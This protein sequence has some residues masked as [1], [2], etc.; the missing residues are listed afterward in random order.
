MLQQF[1][2]IEFRGV[3]LPDILVVE[4]D[5]LIF[6]T[7]STVWSDR[8]TNFH[9]VRSFHSAMRIALGPEIDYF[10]ATI[11]D[12][13]LA[14]GS[15][16]DVLKAIRAQTSIPAVIISGQ[17]TAEFRTAVLDAGADDYMMKPF[18]VREL[19]ARL[20][21]AITVRSEALALSQRETFSIGAVVCDLNRRVLVCGDDKQMLTEA[22]VRL[23]EQLH[24]N[25]NA[26]CSKAF[27]YKNVFFREFDPRDKTLDVYIS[28]IRKKLAQFEDASADQIQ[29]AR[30]AG[31][32]L[33][34]DDPLRAAPAD[35][36]KKRSG[37]DESRQ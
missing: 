35:Q 1:V 34:G 21:R 5:E 9:H 10:D 28:R 12:V 16:I 8:Q 26:V 22:E 18:S 2:L 36:R 33:V 4:D 7:I 25:R 37:T 3:E 6:D 32:R 29:T 13:V 19:E 14:G 17:G 23:I 31:Y 30:G 11:I 20:S 15:G 24:R 27:L